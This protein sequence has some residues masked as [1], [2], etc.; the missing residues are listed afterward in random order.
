MV[1]LWNKFWMATSATRSNALNKLQ[2]IIIFL[3]NKKIATKD[4]KQIML[5]IWPS[6]ARSSQITSRKNMK[7]QLVGEV[8]TAY[9]NQ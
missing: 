5:D 1:R 2:V 7:T 6:T 8:P 4:R 3:S 9:S